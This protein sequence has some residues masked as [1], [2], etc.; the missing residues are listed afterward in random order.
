[1]FHHDVG[2]FGEKLNPLA[3]GIL[4]IY[5]HKPTTSTTSVQEATD[6]KIFILQA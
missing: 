1:V 6:G 4:K 5:F 2:L 3:T